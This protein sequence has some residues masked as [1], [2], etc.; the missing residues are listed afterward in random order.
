MPDWLGQAKVDANG[1][2][3]ITMNHNKSGI[4][5]IVEQVSTQTGKVSS[6]CT[7][8]ITLNGSL[9]APSAALTP[10]GSSGQGTTAAGLPYVY[11][12]ASDQLN[13]NVQGAIAGDQMTIRSQYQEVLATDPLVR[14]R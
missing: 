6:A 11:L 7:S 2:A 14:G 9:V 4:F 8:W 3:S 13:I 12:S 10:I 1:N 5:W